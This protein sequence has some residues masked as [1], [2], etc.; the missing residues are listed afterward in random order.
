MLRWTVALLLV[1]NLAFF[2]WTRGWLTPVVGVGPQG[3]REP[4]RVLQQVH[5]ERVGV[6]GPEAASAAL[7]GRGGPG[8]PDATDGAPG[9]PAGEAGGALGAGMHPASAVACLEAGPYGPNE[10]HAAQIALAQAGLPPER[11]HALPA[12]Q[13]GAWLVYMGRFTDADTLQH[14]EDELQRIHVAFREVH[15]A[16]ALEPGLSLGRFGDRAG[17]DDALA[18]LSQ[19]GVRTARVVEL[20]APAPVRLLRVQDVA[21]ALAARLQTLQWPGAGTGL[22]PCA[23]ES[24]GSGASAPARAG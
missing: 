13:Q 7:T 6:L 8:V 23:A 5:P 3:D 19:R 21:P 14:K 11:V 24:A 18:R 2:A 12:G 16:P 15:G 20:P 9:A 4:Q 1:A 17:A 22:R 10:L